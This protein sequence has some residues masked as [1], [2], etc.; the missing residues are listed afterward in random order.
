[1]ILQYRSVRQEIVELNK[2]IDRFNAE[3]LRW[4]MR[5]TLKIVEDILNDKA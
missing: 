2:Y 1:M 4:R 3:V 5:Q